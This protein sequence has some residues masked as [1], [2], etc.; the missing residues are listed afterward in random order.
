MA[1]AGG[2]VVG[3][4]VGHRVPVLRALVDLAAVARTGRLE[5][6]LEGGDPLT[7]TVVPV[8]ARNCTVKRDWP[9]ACARSASLTSAC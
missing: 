9:S 1:L 7:E 6:P 2:L 8:R 4:R 5:G 3:G